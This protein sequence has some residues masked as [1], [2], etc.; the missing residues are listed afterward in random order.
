MFRLFIMLLSFSSSLV[1][2]AKVYERRKCLS[3][4]DH[5]C[6]CRPTVIDLNSVELKYYPFMV[7][8]D[9]CSGSCNSANDISTKICYK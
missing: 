2:V 7:S 3:L 1:C 8:L 5:L 6:I 4:N 9:K